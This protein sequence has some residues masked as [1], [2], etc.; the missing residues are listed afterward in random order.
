MEEQE[1]K[2]EISWPRP[3]YVERANRRAELH[4]EGIRGMFILNGGGVLA[5]LTFL[6]QIVQGDAEATSIVQYTTV[7]IGFLLAGLVALAPINHRRYES[8]R[9]FDHEETKLARSEV[10]AS[11]SSA[12][13]CIDALLCIR[14]IH[15][16]S[17]SVGMEGVKSLTSRSTRSRA[18]TR[19]PG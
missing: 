5:L 12:V 15:C 7:A 11:A 1:Q 10:R 4:T 13:L 17:R 16:T 19:A 18:K 9:L 14:R 8:S 2:A 6:T 3:D